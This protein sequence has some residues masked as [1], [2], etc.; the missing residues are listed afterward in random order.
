MAPRSAQTRAVSRAPHGF[1]AATAAACLLAGCRTTSVAVQNL[2]AVLSSSDQF[3]YQGATTTPLRDLLE[4]GFGAFLAAPFGRE[5]PQPEVQPIPNPTK[6]SVTELIRL[7]DSTQGGRAWR[8][9][10][11]VRVFARFAVGAPSQLARERALLELV[12]HARRLG[13]ESLPPLD[14][15]E[16]SANAPEL[17]EALDGLV[18]AARA[19]LA[20]GAQASETSRADFEAAA[21]VLQAATID[22]AGGSRLLRALGPFLRA[23]RLPSDARERLEALSLDVQRRLVMQALRRGLSDRSSVA[24]AAA[25]RAAI[26]LLGDPF[27]IE[28]VFACTGRGDVKQALGDR[29][30]DF[31]LPQVPAIYGEV[32]LAVTDHFRVH[33]LPGIAT[34]HTPDALRLRGSLFTGLLRMAAD[35]FLFDDTSRHGA[36]AALA[37]VSS[38]ELETFREEEWTE[39]FRELSAELQAEIERLEAVAPPSDPGTAGESERLP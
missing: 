29:F 27:A 30:N 26:E 7:A 11:S 24:R 14:D 25:Y 13:V 1:L 4:S 10:E 34:A 2:D 39:W 33:G 19:R 17:L 12:P 31:K 32:H 23:P 22:V 9:N 6:L 18:D 35:D 21:D 36:M 20:D 37:A 3:R 16:I 28:A 5:A 8:Q 15:A 38:G